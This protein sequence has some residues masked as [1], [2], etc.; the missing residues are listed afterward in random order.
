[1]TDTSI[2]F[3][4]PLM[5]LAVGVL[6]AVT[7]GVRRTFKFGM[8]F[9]LWLRQM[10]MIL[11]VGLVAFVQGRIGLE[12]IPLL[13]GLIFVSLGLIVESVGKLARNLGLPQTLVKH[14]NLLLNIS[15]L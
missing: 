1:M 7:Y 9:R 4:F 15:G 14:C 13:V 6:A 2:P 3:S 12:N 5:M 10:P 8:T 11:G